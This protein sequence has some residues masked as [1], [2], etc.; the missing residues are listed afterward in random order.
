MKLKKVNGTYVCYYKDADNK[1]RQISTKQTNLKEARAIVEEAGISQLERAALAKTLS[2]QVVDTLL[3]RP[4]IKSGEALSSWVE[5]L[6][7]RGRSPTTQHSYQR[8][9]EAWL[10]ESRLWDKKVSDITTQDVLDYVNPADD[11]SLSARK[12]RLTAITGFC[13]FCQGKG[14]LRNN[15]TD[16]AFV[17][18]RG[19]S[20]A[21]KEGKKRQPFSEAEYQ[22]LI[23]YIDL[24]LIHP[25]DSRISV[26]N[27]RFWQ[28]A[29]PMAYWTGLRLSDICCL[30]WDSVEDG[31]LVVWTKKSGS[32]VSLPLDDP[33]IGSG[34]MRN[35]LQDLPNEHDKY[36]FPHYRAIQLDPT[37]R[38]SLSKDFNRWVA[39]AGLEQTG[40]TF[41]CLR[42]AF[43]TRL[44][45][46][47]RSIDEIGTLVG[48]RDTQTTERYSH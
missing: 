33:L 21:Q 8:T 18:I 26:A 41:H 46:A 31:Q 37:A 38:S 48:H 34:E 43:V 14:Y 11:L 30:E 5:R 17:K 36:V 27:A 39:R 44:K 20:H 42:H 3:A 15:P 13:S 45:R 10:R 40:K 6:D 32:R 19:L 1:T 24:F 12:S 22:R 28:S 23:R 29:I 47:G 9:V 2:E 4:G 16:D 35:V 7:E 25:G